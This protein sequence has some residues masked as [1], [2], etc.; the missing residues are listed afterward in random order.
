MRPRGLHPD[1][2]SKLW[3][4]KKMEANSKDDVPQVGTAAGLPCG[5]SHTE[6]SS[7]SPAV[8]GEGNYRFTQGANNTDT[9]D[10]KQ[11]KLEDLIN[12]FARKDSIR[13]T[14]PGTGK[15][16]NPPVEEEQT[17]DTEEQ[18]NTDTRKETPT[19]EDRPKKRKKLSSPITQQVGE[20]QPSTELTKLKARSDALNTFT[21]DNKNVHKEIKK[22]AMEIASLVKQA[23]TR[24]KHDTYTIQELRKELQEY[25][26]TQECRYTKLENE[27]QELRIAYEKRFQDI[28]NHGGDKEHNCYKC[29]GQENKFNLNKSKINNY[30]E[31]AEVIELDW[32]EDS[33]KN[34]QTDHGDLFNNTFENVVYFCDKNKERQTKTGKRILNRHPELSEGERIA[35]NGGGYTS[36]KQHTTFNTKEG[37]HVREKN[38]IAFFYDPTK[39]EDQT[40]RDVFQLCQELRKLSEEY[41][42][43]RITVVAPQTIKTGNMKKILEATFQ[44]TEFSLILRT[45][46]KKK[47][48]KE[49]KKNAGDNNI[50]VIES[51][52]ATYADTVKKLKDGLKNSDTLE[53]IK[54][55]KKTS[56]GKVLVRVSE[57]ADKDD[58]INKL[59]ENCK[60]TVNKKMR[61]KFL[62]IKDV[63]STADEEDIKEAMLNTNLINYHDQLEVKALRPMKNGNQIAT[64]WMEETD[65]RRLLDLE[66]LRVGL[67]ICQLQERIEILRCYRCWAYNHKAAQ[68]RGEDRSEKCRKCTGD[69]HKAKD[70]N[71]ESFC[72]NCEERG[73]T[74]GSGTCGVFQKAF[75]MAKSNKG[76]RNKNISRSQSSR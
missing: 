1:R 27:L 6:P 55:V 62:H 35:C 39:Q 2:K 29:S 61:R 53:Y 72:P 74:A 4:S 3:F 66:K 9:E 8:S 36:I 75:R 23:I 41:E 58:V 22:F 15:L 47:E 42:T 70:C 44:V 48:Y 16:T 68:C 28:E 60:I 11:K 69:G 40:Q 54:G 46:K 17:G 12:P 45:R 24:H 34:V 21:K 14:P 57:T 26:E 73:H 64:I 7:V 10:E 19:S 65:C 49:R 67:N 50:I 30:E 38:I 33:F 76:W 59:I 51:K 5:E 31:L 56:S 13:R 71:E 18:K 52:E 25:R 32:S 20:I 37:G 43:R 63:D